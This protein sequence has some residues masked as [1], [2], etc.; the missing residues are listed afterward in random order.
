VAWDGSYL[1]LSS[2]FKYLGQATTTGSL[3]ASFGTDWVPTGLAYDGD[4]LWA[5]EYNQPTLYHVATAGSIVESFSFPAGQPWGLG[6]DG[7]YLWV[8]NKEGTG[9]VYQAYFSGPA[10]AP[11]S[12]GGVKAL[13]R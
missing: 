8:T 13:Y 4:Y 7:E 2:Y 12:F 11:A 10:V 1:W 9:D 6:F 3:V 5:A